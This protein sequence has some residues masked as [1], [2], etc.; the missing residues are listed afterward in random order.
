MINNER[1]IQTKSANWSNKQ[2]GRDYIAANRAEKIEIAD[3][4]HFLNIFLPT[5]NA[6][7]CDLPIHKNSLRLTKGV[8]LIQM[9]N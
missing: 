5:D 6:H 3:P 8:K 1:D 9:S 2:A 7:M 4:M